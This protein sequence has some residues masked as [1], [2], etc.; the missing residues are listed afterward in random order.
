MQQLHD[1]LWIADSPL[2]F[3]GLEVGTRM[4]VVRLPGPRMLLHSPIAASEALLR[5][6]Q[7][8][9]PVSYLIAPNRLH[10]LFVGEWKEAC[11]EAEIHAAPGLES[12]RPDLT[13]DGV[14]GEAPDPGWA[15]ELDQTLLHGFPFANEVVFFHRP[16]ATLIAS[17]LAFNIGHQSPLPTRLFFRLAGGYGRLAPSVLERLMIRDRAAFRGSLERIFEWPFERVVVAHGEVS[18]TGGRE[19][20]M[21]SYE[22]ILKRRQP[23]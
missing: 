21:R 13:I 7:T 3:G 10:H 18:E 12:K 1:D 17:D 20:L 5:E 19:E 11:P 8:L 14:L 4:T 9:G 16:S 22:W 23:A 15:E 6:V 2:R